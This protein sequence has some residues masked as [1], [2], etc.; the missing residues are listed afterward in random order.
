ML[1]ILNGFV[2]HTENSTALQMAREA[3]IIML[4]LPS[5]TTHCMQPL[6]I[7]FFRPLIS[8]CGQEADKWMR[9][10]P[11]HSS[12]HFQVC[13]LFG[14]A[15]NKAASVETASG[16]FRNGG[17]WPVDPSVFKDCCFAPT[18]VTH[19]VDSSGASSIQR[20]YDDFCTCE[21]AV[22][23]PADSCSFTGGLQL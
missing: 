16:R 20:Y 19:R 4:S 12:T 14:R 3:G 15:Y 17:I 23:Q 11:G 8:Y 9:H 7:A 2:S 6:D 18:E 13:Q 22:L 10:N 5:N 1:L 21:S